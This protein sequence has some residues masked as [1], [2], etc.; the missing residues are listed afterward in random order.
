MIPAVSEDFLYNF[1]HTA[2]PSRDY[3]LNQNE[4]RIIGFVDGLEAVK[5]AIYF[6]LN[7]ERYQYLIYSWDY[8]V[9]F[10]DMFGKPYSYIVPEV[11]R[12]VTECLRQDD[13]IKAVTNFIIEKNKNNVHA[14]FLVETIY[15]E[16]E[17]EVNLNV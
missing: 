4:K 15:G 17:S 14:T 5:Q 2:M 3:K 7:T 1:T 6:M 8:G 11:E 9:E 13:R 12:R 10:E 16:I